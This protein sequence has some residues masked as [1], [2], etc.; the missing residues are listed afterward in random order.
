M[1]RWQSK[2]QVSQIKSGSSLD[3]KFEYKLK[4][5]IMTIVVA[6]IHYIF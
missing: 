3:V 4:E 1:Q 5:Y 2:L 6:Y